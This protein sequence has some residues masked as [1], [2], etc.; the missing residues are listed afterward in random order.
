MTRWQDEALTAGL[1]DESNPQRRVVHKYDIRFDGLS[2][3][4]LRARGRSVLDVG[5]NRAHTLYDFALNGAALVHGCDIY[6]PGMAAARQWFS[7]VA[8]CEHE[9]A[10]LD[11][12]KGARELNTAFGNRRYDIV[13]MLGVYHKLRREMTPDLLSGLMRNLGLRTTSYFGWSGYPE[14]LAI[15]DLDM[16]QCGLQR[17]ATSEIAGPGRPA[18]IWQRR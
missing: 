8:D 11:L 18:A 3:L 17:I 6:G 12:S 10:A 9:F 14:E 16:H 5:C 13:L 1:M 2:D 15:I 7:E 4:M